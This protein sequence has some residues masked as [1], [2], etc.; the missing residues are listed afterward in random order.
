VDAVVDAILRITPNADGVETKAFI[1]SLYVELYS[2]GALV[3]GRCPRCDDSGT[4]DYAGFAMEPCD[5]PQ[6]QYGATYLAGLGSM[7]ALTDIAAE[8]V[9][10]I[11]A[12]GWTPEHDDAHDVGELADAAACYARGEQMSSVWPWSDEWWKPSDRRRN[13]IKAGAL[14]VAEIERLDRAEKPA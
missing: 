12:E 11:E 3:A 9:R 4:K 1:A 5:N 8:R 6:C 7:T 2:S 14:I 10:Q 13:L